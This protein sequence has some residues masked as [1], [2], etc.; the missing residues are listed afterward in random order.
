MISSGSSGSEEDGGE[1][2]S[3]CSVLSQSAHPHEQRSGHESS[4]QPQHA[5][6]GSCQ[7]PH[8]QTRQQRHRPLRSSS[9]R[10]RTPSRCSPVVAHLSSHHPSS[11]QQSQGF[12]WPVSLP[13]SKSHLFF[14]FLPSC[15][16]FSSLERLFFLIVKKK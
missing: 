9:R 12:N 3:N 15:S 11:C 4:S 10:S 1:R 6:G 8:A 2:S 5:P 7:S 16:L 14:F 13:Q